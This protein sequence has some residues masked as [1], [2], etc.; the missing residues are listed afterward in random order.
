MVQ[1]VGSLLVWVQ[2]LCDQKKKNK[3]Q[4]KNPHYFN[5]GQQRNNK[6]QLL[7]LIKVLDK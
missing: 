4:K 5:K 1:W 6:I 2:S 7:Y 3:K